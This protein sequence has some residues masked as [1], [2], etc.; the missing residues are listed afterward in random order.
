MNI[1]SVKLAQE[2]SAFGLTFVV[3]TEVS[4]VISIKTLADILPVI[5]QCLLVGDV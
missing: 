4:K 2:S 3:R 1:F 5:K